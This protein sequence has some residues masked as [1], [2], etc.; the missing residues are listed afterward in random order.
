[1]QTLCGAAGFRAVYYTKEKYQKPHFATPHGITGCIVLCYLCVQLVAG[2]N[3]MFPQII[4]S[5][6]VP[7]A[8]LRMMHGYSGTFLFFLAT[9]TL[10]GGVTSDYFKE[11][12]QPPV[13]Y[14]CLAAPLLIF[15]TIVAQ[16]V[17][18]KSSSKAASTDKKVN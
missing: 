5:K 6:F 13:W 2:F 8:R 1:M 12:V 15:A 11:L 3:V 16:V 7:Y 4:A 9:L 10:L 18:K 17:F 14:V